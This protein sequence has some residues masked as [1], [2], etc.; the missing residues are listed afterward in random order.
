MPRGRGQP[1]REVPAGTRFGTFEVIREV[2]RSGTNRRFECRCTG[3]ESTGIKW[4]SNLVQGKTTCLTCTPWTVV[5]RSGREAVLA[6]R[7]A[8]SRESADGRIC[9]TCGLWKPW[10]AFSAD[11]RRVS[12]KTSNCMECGRWRTIRATYGITR[13]DW[14]RLDAIGQGGCHLCFEDESLGRLA[15]DHDHSHCGPGRGC[16]QCVRGLLCRTCNRMLGHIESKP[17]LRARFADYLERRPLAVS[18]GT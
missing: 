16:K 15:V 1:P 12:G 3:C 4:L 9:L 18:T 8:R 7:R 11:A 5:N 2:E 13:E 14:A 6:A 17:A 10:A